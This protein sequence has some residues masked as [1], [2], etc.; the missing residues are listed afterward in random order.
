MIFKATN[1]EVG[2]TYQIGNFKAG[3]RLIFAL[4]TPQKFSY[5][6]DHR[7]NPDACDHV[8]KLKKKTNVYELRWEDIYGL[9]DRDYNDL[10]VEVSIT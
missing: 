4:R 7:Y 3:T 5:F 9:G 10:V 6:T 1:S 2:K 8:I